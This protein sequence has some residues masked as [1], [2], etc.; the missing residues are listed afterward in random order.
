M[1]KELTELDKRLQEIALKNWWQFVNLIG[2]DEI[3]NAKA[4]ILRQ[5]GHSYGQIKNK[6]GLTHR[7]AQY[8]CGKCDVKSV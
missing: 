4:C 8:N 3:N 6:L 2:A 7:Q 5:D 1:N